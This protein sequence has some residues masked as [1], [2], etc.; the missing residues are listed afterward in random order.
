MLSTAQTQARDRRVRRERGAAGGAGAVSSAQAELDERDAL[1][2]SFLRALQAGEQTSAQLKQQPQRRRRRESLEDVSVNAEHHRTRVESHEAWCE[3]TD[4]QRGIAPKQASGRGRRASVD[5]GPPPAH[6]PPTKPRPRRHSTGDVRDQLDPC[7][8][9]WLESHTS[10]PPVNCWARDQGIPLLPGSLF[11]PILPPPG[12]RG[13]R[14]PKTSSTAPRAGSP[15]TASEFLASA[16]QARITPRGG[17]HR[18][19]STGAELELLN[20]DEG[21]LACKLQSKC[22]G[23]FLAATEIVRWHP[24]IR[25]KASRRYRQKTK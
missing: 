11:G 6:P 15:P 17:G 18:S 14:Q 23:L 22:C 16:V 20:G 8:A 1:R 2:N 19:L 9:H 4:Q 3:Q 25:C 24:H 7:A 12:C 13:T 10:H 21:M 5:C